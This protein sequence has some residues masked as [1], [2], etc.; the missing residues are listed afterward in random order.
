MAF[1]VGENSYLSVEAASEYFALRLY[2][3]PWTSA[4]LAQKQAALVM[5]TFAIDRMAVWCGAPTEAGQPLCF[6]RT[7]LSDRN[8]NPI[9]ST[10][11][12]KD[13]QDAVCEQALAYLQMDTTRKPDSIAKGIAS[14]S[15]GSLS[16]SYASIKDYRQAKVCDAAYN[17]LLMSG[18]GDIEENGDATVRNVGITR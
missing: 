1:V 12:P 2:A 13:I 9:A 8:G 3:E 7:G 14:A 10:A 16:V 17:I 18:L 11:I 6:P 5:A 4:E 15:V